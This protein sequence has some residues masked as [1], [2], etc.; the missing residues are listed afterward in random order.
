M[1]GNGA[2]ICP[3]H[4]PLRFYETGMLLSCSELRKDFFPLSFCPFASF[5]S[6][7]VPNLQSALITMFLRIRR[8]TNYAKYIQHLLPSISAGVTSATVIL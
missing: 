6:L 1:K 5:S 4:V 2:P 7:T 3:S 8:L